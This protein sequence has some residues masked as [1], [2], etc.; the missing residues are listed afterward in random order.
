M[1][2]LLQNIKCLMG[3]FTMCNV[4]DKGQGHLNGHCQPIPLLIQIYIVQMSHS[5]KSEFVGEFSYLS[6]KT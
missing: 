2:V 1:A 3:K 4:T 6:M 5:F